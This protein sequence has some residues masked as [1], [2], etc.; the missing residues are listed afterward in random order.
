M[1]SDYFEDTPHLSSR[2]SITVARYSLIMRQVEHHIQDAF[3][4]YAVAVMQSSSI[5]QGLAPKGSANE[6]YQTHFEHIRSRGITK[7]DLDL[8]PEYKSNIDLHIEPFVERLTELWHPR[9]LTFRFVEKEARNAGRKEDFVIVVDETNETP[10]SLKNY[11]N[12]I[13]RAQVSAGTFNSLACSFLFESAGGVGMLIDSVSGMKFK[14][15]NRKKRN[16]ALNLSGRSSLVHNFEAL[17]ALNDEI[18]KVFVYSPDF[19]FLDEVAFDK[20]RKRVGKT[21]AR[22][23]ERLLTS[24]PEKHI[25][26]VM[27]SRIGFDGDCEQLLFDPRSYSDSITVPKFKHLIQKVRDDADLKFEVKGQSL[28]FVFSDKKSDLL[29]VDIPFTINKNGAWI[30]EKYPGKRLH[31]KEGLALAHG[32]R[33]PKKSKE[34][35]TSVNTYVDFESAGILMKT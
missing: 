3:E 22:I 16:A 26:E 25:R 29:S 13:S 2:F 15:S 35:A 27:L 31:K 30:S 18:K 4:P 14:G 8:Y 11:R 28:S 33:R 17:D 20:E 12:S 32:Q 7:A 21:G 23:L 6:H 10:C 9:T 19:E 1:L 34:L 24:I 5:D